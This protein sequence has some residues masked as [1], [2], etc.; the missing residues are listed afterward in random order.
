MIQNSFIFLDKVSYKK[1]Q[2]FWKQ[3]VK[4]WDDFLLKQK[5][6]GISQSTKKQ[7]DVA[8]RLAKLNLIYN[9]VS[10]FTEL[11]KPKETWRLYNL[12]KNEALYLDIETSGWDITV[13]GMYNKTMKQFVKNIS[14]DKK[15]I[16]REI[17]KHK[18]II[19]FNGSS[20]DLP[21]INRFL[22]HEI[23]LPHIDLR[24]VCTRIGLKGGLKA[25]E[26][27]LKI[28]RNNKIE[29]MLGNEAVYCWE[30]WQHTKNR[31]YL[32][33]LLKYNKA[34]TVN[35]KPLADFAVERLWKTL[36]S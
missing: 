24:H 7:Y 6:K 20:F 19:T 2:N 8:I 28:K 13:I 29:S 32:E 16:L 17:Y 27:Q 10:F 1:E 15:E 22:K 4:T 33:L 3:G 26:K 14:M 30:L 36:K 18:L 9:N 31:K 34:D 12:Y 23:K 35:L 5:I 25:I 11:L 21:M